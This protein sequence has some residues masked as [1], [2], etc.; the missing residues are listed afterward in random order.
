MKHLFP[1]LVLFAFLIPKEGAGQYVTFKETI[2][3]TTSKHFKKV[4]LVGIGPMET[5]VFLDNLTA[6]LIT[7]FASQN[8]QAW[9]LYLG[10]S[11]E[12]ANIELKKV[13]DSTYDALFIF[14]PIDSLHYYNISFDYY[15]NDPFDLS[16]SSPP[17][18]RSNSTLGT[19]TYV[20][21]IRTI[22]YEDNFNIQLYNIHIQKTLIWEASLKVDFNLRKNSI[23][24]EV[25]KAI[26]S[27]LKTSRVLK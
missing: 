20:T 24:T 14:S 21:P 2:T 8:V 5:R 27:S 12:Q 16:K 19:A 23:Y 6:K 22:S 7:K 15:P 11:A 13:L 4:L 9:F 25:S 10:K 1:Y 26:I 18:Q 3:D 17:G